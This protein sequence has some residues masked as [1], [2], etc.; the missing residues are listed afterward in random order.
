MNSE[1]FVCVDCDDYLVD[2]AIDL[3]IK[4]WNKVRDKDGICGIV[5]KKG[6]KRPDNR[7][8]SAD[9]PISGLSTQFELYSHGFVGETTLV[10]VTNVIKQYPF[11]EIQGEKFVTE[12]YIY[13]QIDQ[14]YKYIIL[15][16]NLTLCE[17]LDDGY[18]KNYQ[19]LYMNNPIGYSMYYNQKN[20][21]FKFAFVKRMKYLVYYISYAKFGKLTNIYKDSSVKGL[22]YFFAYIVSYIYMKKTRRRFDKLK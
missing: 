7:Y 9:F 11:P 16:K 1:L 4:E 10:F 6:M 5:G 13:D 17:Y 3:I 18:S 21:L 20:C 22:P 19:K 8:D 15:N 14:K 2:D 12:S